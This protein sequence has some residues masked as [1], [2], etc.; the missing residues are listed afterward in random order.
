[1]GYVSSLSSTVTAYEPVTTSGEISFSGLGN[2][3]DFSE[4]IDATVDAESFKKEAYEAQVEENEYIV[5]VLEQLQEEIDDFNETLDDM[6][7]LD[8]FYSMSA[9]VTDDAISAEVTGEA[10]DE[11]HNV[12]VNQLAQ[13]DVWVF[14]GTGYDDTE[15]VVTSDATTISVTYGGE[16]IDV[17]I[18]AGTTLEGMVDT[19]NASISARDKFEA[20]LIYD[21]SVYYFVLKSAETGKDNA[22]E[23]TDVGSVSGLDL[24]DLSQ[25]QTA[26]NAQLKVDGFPADN[27]DGTE[28]W[29]ERSTNSVDDVIDGMTLDLNETTDSEGVNISVEFDTDDMFDT[30]TEFV[31]DLNQIILDIQLLTGRVTEEE[32]GETGYT[33]DNYAMDIMYSNIKSIISSGALGFSAYD[34]DTGGDYYH[35]LSQIGFSTDTDEGSDTYGQII[36]DEDELE[37][38]LDTDPQAVAELF[39]AQA[40]GESDSDDFQVISVINGVTEAGEY[41]IEY[42]VEGGVLTSAY[43]NGEETSIDGWTILATSGDA[44]GLYLSI[45]S[46]TDGTHSGTARVK[47]GKIGELSDALDNI[48]NEETG[49]LPIVIDSYESRVTSLENQIYN[50]EQR[51]DALETSLTR[52]YA[53]LDSLLSTYESRSS[54]LSTLLASS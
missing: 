23:I 54:T 33:I 43:I 30:I 25:T 10:D 31:E 50:E 12:V 32:D 7:E 35:A 49:T 53:A 34:E 21:G 40:S 8:E 4:I 48:T 47:Q 18:A 41:D 28:R 27:D 19:I 20:D 16:S 17:D 38:A 1:M 44:K 15:T 52:K 46:Q 2:G 39:A 29:L 26:Q 45:G 37:E 5:D 11:T 22:I 9:N 51:L 6:D 3:T 36:L 24:A 14:D 42:T 13:K